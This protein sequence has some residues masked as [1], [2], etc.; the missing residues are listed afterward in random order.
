[1]RISVAVDWG[2]IS[3][4]PDV[5]G[6]PAPLACQREVFEFAAE[7]KRLDTRN[8]HFCP[9]LRACRRRWLWWRVPASHMIAFHPELLGGS[10]VDRG[11][12]GRA[13]TAI[14][15]TQVAGRSISLVVRALAS[16]PPSARAAPS[17]RQIDLQF[18]CA[19]RKET[20]RCC[21]SSHRTSRT[22]LKLCS[23]VSRPMPTRL[24]WS[25]STSGSR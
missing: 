19:S 11:G 23:R 1:M 18:R 13:W 17:S 20:R 8:D 15:G 21:R 22:Q 14:K 25:R 10:S 12:R 7:Q 6:E 9:A 5:L 4:D 24:G 3:L 16:H 2:S